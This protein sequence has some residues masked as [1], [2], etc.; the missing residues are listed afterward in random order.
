[1]FFSPTEA[2]T[3]YLNI[4]LA[5]GLVL[6][7]PFIL[8]QAWKFAEPAV[9]GSIKSG[10]VLFVLS[11]TLAFASG[12]LFSYFFLLPPALRFLL[13]FG[14]PDLQPMISAQSYI[15][16]VVW[17]VLGTGLVFEMP[18]ISYMLSRLG[19]IDHRTLR[20][21]YSYAVVA[22]L[23]AAAII[24]PTPDIFNMLLLA[25]PMLLLYELS[26]WIAR[27]AGKRRPV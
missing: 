23:V 8:Y 6:S 18:V 22:I 20:A 26:I 1:M 9:A 16:F 25:A 2:L 15:S 5:A 3:L 27:F 12:A 17:T 13:G 14:G 24:T 19:I 11:V 4:S 7:M 21:K 10:P